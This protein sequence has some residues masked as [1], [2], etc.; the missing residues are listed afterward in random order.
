[1]RARLFLVRGFLVRTV[2]TGRYADQRRRLRTL[3]EYRTCRRLLEFL[4][5]QRPI[6]VGLR[7]DPPPPHA[8]T[9]PKSLP[10]SATPK[11]PSFQ[12]PQ[13][14][15]RPFPYL[16]ATSSGT[17]P[18]LLS[19]INSLMFSNQ[20]F[21]DL[22]VPWTRGLTAPI[23]APAAEARRP[24]LGQSRAVKPPAADQCRAGSSRK[25]HPGTRLPSAST[26]QM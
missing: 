4:K 7:R 20:P 12:V 22:P 3:W 16:N 1:M 9:L 14:T 25:P 26:G 23:S 10:L 11:V 18:S 5:S 8:M 19:R 17:A 2:R 21:G 13:R 15:T 6:P 24:G